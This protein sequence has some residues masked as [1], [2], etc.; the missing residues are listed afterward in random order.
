MDAMTSM[1]QTLSETIQGLIE[2]GN[3]WQTRPNSS[4]RTSSLRVQ[5]HQES[6]LTTKTVKL[7]FPR[8][9]GENPSRWVY[10]AQQY[11]QLYSIPL[12]QRILLAFYRKEYE[13]LVWFQDAKDAG[14]F[15]SWEAFV[16]SLHTR[17]GTSTYDDPMEALTS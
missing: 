1:L 14:Q 12:N 3:R 10:I 11:F 2:T 13:D 8:I 6:V 4:T 9:R 5:G 15:T 17:F 16:K 7:E